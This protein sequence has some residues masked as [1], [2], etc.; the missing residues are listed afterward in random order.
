[1]WNIFVFFVFC[2]I[3]LDLSYRNC[4]CVTLQC[5]CVMW[6][7][8]QTWPHK[9]MQPSFF[10]ALIKFYLYLSTVIVLKCFAIVLVTFRFLGKK[11]YFYA[12]LKQTFTILTGS[13]SLALS[14]IHTHIHS[15][16]NARTNKH[17]QRFGARWSVRCPLKETFK[18]KGQ[19]TT[20]FW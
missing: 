17:L 1:M 6:C 12:F 3:Y 15:I 2:F 13:S 20:G 14:N 19:R 16:I 4:V 18:Q 8:V 9:Q 10:K 7:D 5:V 11:I